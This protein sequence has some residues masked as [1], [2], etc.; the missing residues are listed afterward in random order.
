MEARPEVRGGLGLGGMQPSTMRGGGSLFHGGTGFRSLGQKS[1][2]LYV[3]AE[4]GGGL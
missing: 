1:G 4:R 2:Q 3:P